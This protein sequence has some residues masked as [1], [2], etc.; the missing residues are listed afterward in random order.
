Y[1]LEQL[2]KIEE[3]INTIAIVERYETLKNKCSANIEYFSKV[4]L[5]VNEESW[6]NKIKEEKERFI[7]LRDTLRDKNEDVD[8]STEINNRLNIL[9]E[10]YITYYVD[11]HTKSRLGINESAKKGEI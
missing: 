10:E 6:K 4:E 11:M 2:E 5:V 9:K 7:V 3:G 1:T 8:Y